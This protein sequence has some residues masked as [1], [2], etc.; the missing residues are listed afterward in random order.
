LKLFISLFMHPTRLTN[1]AL[2]ERRQRYYAHEPC[3]SLPVLSSSLQRRFDDWFFYSG[4]PHSHRDVEDTYARLLDHFLSP[5]PLAE[6]ADD[7]NTPE[8]ILSDLTRL[9]LLLEYTRHSHFII[10]SLSFRRGSY[11][12]FSAKRQLVL[13]AI[14]EGAHGPDIPTNT[15]SFRLTGDDRLLSLSE[16]IYPFGDRLMHVSDFLQE[17]VDADEDRAMRYALFCKMPVS[18]QSVETAHC[19]MSPKNE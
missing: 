9:Q 7:D 3:R 10:C 1:E 8:T 17:W 13:F 5:P 15:G 4:G 14:Y 16:F 2:R 6:S 11:Y 18:K 12:Y 19:C